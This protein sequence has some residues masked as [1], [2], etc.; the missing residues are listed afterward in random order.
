[1]I[2]NNGFYY[3]IHKWTIK[4]NK[5]D[6][7][8]QEIGVVSNCDNFDDIIVQK[9]GIGETYNFG[10]RAIFGN[11][12]Y[13]NDMYYGS[14]NDNGMIRCKKDINAK[15]GWCAKDEITVILN[16]NH[17]NIQFFLNG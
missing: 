2:S 6:V 16:L 1:M 10:A 12:L 11:E 3:G 13:T 4:I 14:Y 9:G 8:R 17:G 15:I 5:C 7:Y